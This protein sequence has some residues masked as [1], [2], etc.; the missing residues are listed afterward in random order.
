MPKIS[1]VMALYNTPFSFLQATVESIL[2]QTFVDFEL[3]IVDDASELK[4]QDFFARFNDDRIKY[5]KLEENFGPGKARNYGIKKAI[6]EYVAIV[7]SDDIYL[8]Q[9]FERQVD[10]LDKN[11][12]ISLISCAFKQSNNGKIPKVVEINEDI[13]LC[14]L[15]N[16][17]FANP[18]MMFRRNVFVEKKLYYPE[19]K[20]F[21]EDYELWINA[22]FAGVKMANLNEVLMIYTRRPGQLSKAKE[23]LQE[24]I[25][26]NLYKKI[27]LKIGIEATKEEIDLHRDIYLQNF[28]KKD[29]KEIS[30]WFDNIILHNKNFSLFDESKLVELKQM[31]LQKAYKI[32]NR[33]FKLKIGKN[34]LCVSKNFEIYL[35]ARE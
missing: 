31:T 7:D 15:F 35:E 11:P 34:N 9:R 28:E 13:K 21:G 16:S 18:A 33:L 4:Y 20:K 32:K 6:G 5:F 19:D 27:L 10:F 24:N 22:M 30:A 29:S 26:K 8:P 23:D 1:A 17:P 12:E 2:N 14:M 3:I 25:L